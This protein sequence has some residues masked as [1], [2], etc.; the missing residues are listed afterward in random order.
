LRG[1]CNTK[2]HLTEALH[3]I[4]SRAGCEVPRE[5]CWL[6]FRCCML[7]AFECAVMRPLKLAGWGVFQVIA[8]QRSL[9]KPSLR[10]NALRMRWYA[11]KS[12]NDLLNAH[13]ECDDEGVI[14]SYKSGTFLNVL[15]FEG[16]A[17]EDDPNQTTLGFEDTGATPPEGTSDNQSGEKE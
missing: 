5:M 2:E 4:L 14:T 11:P 1:K 8:S 15:K 16:E 3:G 7:A 12:V 10:G 13:A 9:E 17:E 6:V